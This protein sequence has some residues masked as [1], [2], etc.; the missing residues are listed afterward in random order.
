MTDAINI[1]IPHDWTPR[2]YQIPLLRYLQGGGTRAV[3]L[4]HRRAGKDSLA[5]HWCTMA[6]VK[7]LGVYWHVLPTLKQGRKAVWEN[8]TK[9]GK[10]FLDAFP[11]ELIYNRRNDEMTITFKDPAN[12]KKPGSFYQVIG[13]GD[14]DALMGAN[15]VGIVFSEYSLGDPVAWELTR[16]M[17][18][19][20][21]G[22]ALFIYTA[23]GH[24]HGFKLYEMAEKNPKWFCQR[25]T[26]DDT[27]ALMPPGFASISQE[28]IQ[29][30]REGG[31]TEAKIQ[32][33]Y[34]CS[35][36][37]PVEG[38]FYGD[39]MMAAL[40]EGRITGVPHDPAL[41]VSTFWDI[42]IGDATAIWWAQ[43]TR[44]GEIHLIDY[45]ETNGVGLAH[46]VNELAKRREERGYTYGE[47]IAPH[48]MAAKE[49]GSGKSRIEMAR[50]LGVT[51][52][53]APKLP[54]D[55]GI[56]AVRAAL[57]RCWF[58]EGCGRGID[59]LRNYRREEVESKSDGVVTF[60]K[61]HPLHDWASHA[62][63]SFRYGMV[64]GRGPRNREPIKYPDKGAPL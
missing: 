6:M 56:Q 18:A 48:D 7:R 19:E 11:E 33:E 23:R 17:L 62:A 32:S 38:A 30:D 51:F 14:V 36:D 59:A 46:Y 55:D 27:A 34:Y 41:P 49:F 54:V 10:L 63:D 61:P 8:R 40:D 47:H 60:Y 64:G 29:E 5:L 50:G 26:V 52:R 43:T 31:M 44:G 37:A 9:D 16:P 58:D 28:A 12:P 4:W 45:Y 20:N 1:R 22:W 24:N 25:L 42:G 53:V 2:P 35:F 21:G 39:L 57:P 13:S 15:P 3:A